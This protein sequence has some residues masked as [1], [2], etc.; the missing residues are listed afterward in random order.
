MTQKK[1]EILVERG[2]RTTVWRGT[3]ERLI[4]AFSYTLEIGHSWDSRVN[5]NPKTIT[6]FISNLQKAFSI[7]EQ[8]C[9]NRTYISK[10]TKEDLEQYK[11]EEL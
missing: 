5:K 1:Y 7:K 9:Y 2:E 3:L 6:S 4:S 11:I 8:C 10:A